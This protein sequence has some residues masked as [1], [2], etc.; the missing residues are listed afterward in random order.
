MYED[1]AGSPF[2]SEVRKTDPVWRSIRKCL[3]CVY[4]VLQAFDHL[5]AFRNSEEGVGMQVA[6]RNVRDAVWITREGGP[7][8]KLCPIGCL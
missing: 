6:A 5:C 2:H 4:N 3:V 8:V 1:L 7:L